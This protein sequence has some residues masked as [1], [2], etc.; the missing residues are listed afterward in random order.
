MPA[1]SAASTTDYSQLLYDELSA[2]RT[3]LLTQLGAATAATDTALGAYN[4]S[5]QTF[6]DARLRLQDTTDAERVAAY[7]DRQLVNASLTAK[8]VVA[9]AADSTAK[10]TATTTA[11]ALA[12]ANIK[13]A[14]HAVDT[15]TNTINGIAGVTKSNDVNEPVDKAARTAVEAVAKV[16]LV[17]DEL[18]SSSLAAAIIASQPEAAA[19]Q[20][21]LTDSSNSIAGILSTAD[22]AFTA[23]QAAMQAAQTARATDL[24]DLFGYKAQFAIA[25]TASTALDK[26]IGVVDAVANRSLTAHIQNT[27]ETKKDRTVEKA[28]LAA[29]CVFPD[30]L[31]RHT[32]EVRFFAVPASQAS[33]FDFQTACTNTDFVPGTIL[34]N[35]KEPHLI[36]YRAQLDHDATSASL[37]FG[38]SYVVF[39]LRIPRGESASTPGEPRATDFS[40]P[41]PAI[42]CSVQ[43]AFPVAPGVFPLLD[44]AFLMAFAGAHDEG[45]IGSYEVF[46]S[47]ADTYLNSN[48]EELL[49]ANTLNAANYV[50]VP[51]RANGAT[52]LAGLEAALTR[53]V[54]H[55]KRSLTDN[56]QKALEDALAAFFAWADKLPESGRV[57]L[58]YYSPFATK[59]GR[60]DKTGIWIGRYTDMNGDPFVLARRRYVALVLAVGSVDR[61][62][63]KQAAN[64]LSDPSA[65]F[66]DGGNPPAAPQPPPAAASA[67]R[68]RRR[69]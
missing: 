55:D 3:T 35:P 56:E 58:V 53:Q 36:R 41:T 9:L 2:T 4:V 33:S 48:R 11:V 29:S 19:A 42:T 27:S 37:S 24:A 34:V 54:V 61:Q 16:A 26:T 12:S 25:A 59:S 39:F 23:S 38:E 51:A 44:G 10:A 8:N 18:L 68:S 5:Q 14:R 43:L 28:G 46:F 60:D 45:Y 65:P 40:F 1:N 17:A 62:G 30:R 67:G 22:A 20:Q 50:S 15:L 66:L 13:A 21:A 64:V 49:I 63:L 7:L 32:A 69:S 31:S 57:Y 6:A 52:R 47:P